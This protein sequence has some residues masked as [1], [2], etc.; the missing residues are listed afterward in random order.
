MGFLCH[1]CPHLL[2]VAYEVS[3]SILTPLKMYYGKEK[4]PSVVYKSQLTHYK[5]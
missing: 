1:F 4:H 5:I 2:V 3:S